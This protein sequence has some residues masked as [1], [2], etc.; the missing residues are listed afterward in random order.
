MG[1]RVAAAEGIPQRA[2][3]DVVI[4][5]IDVSI[6]PDEYIEFAAQFP[7]VVNCGAHDIRKSTVS[8]FLLKPRDRW[9]GPVMVKSNF[10]AGG[11]AEALHNL[12]AALR[13]R[14]VPYPTVQVHKS[15]PIYQSMTEVPEAVWNDPNLVVERFLPEQDKKG[16]WRRVW[17]FFGDSERCTRYCGPVPAFTGAKA[18]DRE[19][20]P[21]P[22]ELRAER[23]RLGFDY[24]KFDFVIH[25]GKVVLFDANRTP[26]AS[27]G[28][29]QFPQQFFR[30]LAAGID[31]FLGAARN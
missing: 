5:H 3:A 23:K 15:Y 6:V 8:R 24:G 22:D 9:A 11:S 29:N 31:S 13:N 28:L 18:T 21:V 1:H 16:Y 10:N 12:A 20:A 14:P 25:R 4:L 26:A 2:E 27:G 30:T 19:L 7:V 17:T